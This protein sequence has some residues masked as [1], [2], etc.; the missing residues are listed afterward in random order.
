MVFNY[1]GVEFVQI[2]MLTYFFTDLCS[3]LLLVF[4]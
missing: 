4:Q 3:I 1:S 2:N